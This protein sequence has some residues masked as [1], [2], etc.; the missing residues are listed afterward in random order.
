MLGVGLRA[1]TYEVYLV[2]EHIVHHQ[3]SFCYQSG[4]FVVLKGGGGGGPF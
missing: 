2:L 1:C 3:L 4:A